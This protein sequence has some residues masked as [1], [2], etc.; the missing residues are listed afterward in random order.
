MSG[1][2]SNNTP[3]E[4]SNAP[5][6]VNGSSNGNDNDDRAQ[7]RKLYGSNDDDD[8]GPSVS[9]AKEAENAEDFHKSSFNLKRTRSMGLLDEYIDPMKKLL[10]Q[11]RKENSTTTTPAPNTNPSHQ[12][13]TRY[14]DSDG[15]SYSSDSES[16]SSYSTSSDSDS[17][18]DSDSDSYSDSTSA[19]SSTSNS[20]YSDNRMANEDDVNMTSTSVSPPSV[21]NDDILI[22][23]DDNDVVVEPERH[24]DYLSHNW[25]EDEISN[26]WKYI[27][28]KKKKRDI[29][30]VNAA[31]LENASW[32]TWAKTRNHLKTVSPE[33][34]NWSKDSD[35]TWLYGPIV[36][37]DEVGPEN[38]EENQN[39][40]DA[41]GYGSDDET[42]K[43]LPVINK[44][45]TLPKPDES[46]QLKP[47][48]KKRTVPEIIEENSQ[49][50]LNEAKKHYYEMR[51]A[52]ASLDPNAHIHDDYDL[53]AAKVN[54]Q[55]FQG[56]GKTESQ[57]NSSGTPSASNEND[58]NAAHVPDAT[59]DQ[60]SKQ[61]S[62]G[63]G[64]TN[65]TTAPESAMQKSSLYKEGSDPTT[66]SI[67]TNKTKQHQHN[68]TRPKRHIH[69]NDRVEQCM[70]VKIES[71]SES[72]SESEAEGEGNPL[73]QSS[74]KR[75]NSSRSMFSLHGSDDS[76][77][78]SDDSSDSESDDNGDGLFINARF[79]RR[80]NSVVHSPVSTAPPSPTS[81][82]K[83]RKR[84]VKPA[85][86]LLPATTLNYGSD[87]ESDNSDYNSY[88]NAVSH[89]VN[90]QR[91]YD[92]IYDYNSVYTGDTSNFLPIDN[93]DIVDVPDGINLQTS[94]ADSNKSN[95]N[96]EQSTDNLGNTSSGPKEPTVT[97]A[98]S[99]KP[100]TANI[101]DE[102]LYSSDDQYS[103]SSNTD[104]DEFIE[105]SY[106]RSSGDEGE[107]SNNESDGS[108][109][110]PVQ[111]DPQSSL[112]RTVSLG[113]STDSLRNL[114]QM[115][116]N[117]STR[118]ASHSFI[119]GNKLNDDNDRPTGLATTAGSARPPIAKR[120]ST[121]SFIF[122]S[123]SDDDD[124]D[125]SDDSSF[126]KP[127]VSSPLVSVNPKS[128]SDNAKG[129]R[130]TPPKRTPSSSYLSNTSDPNGPTSSHQH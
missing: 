25:Q 28:L 128:S 100:P 31:R 120:S 59:D 67:L 1:H 18:S 12:T 43:L 124:S 104:D 19:S 50:R 2:P 86:K 92:Y 73:G 82:S 114:S 89:N 70:V 58:I 108:D 130:L 7:L 30:L 53:L 81:L 11:S 115:S 85:I 55:Y 14:R 21:G 48:L 13:S 116:M 34:V 96:F 94:I 129:H 69:F 93:C 84:K 126:G 106:Y 4:N 112:K 40:F 20:T 51:R 45:K 35:V 61:H 33:V 56:S 66:S 24:V 117:S 49:W 78:S 83:T 102:D 44:S 118:L 5:T 87:E 68:A 60:N 16:G 46:V 77:A 38:Q 47:I 111:E 54:A 79:S 57:T 71:D 121:R 123:D 23:Q 42:S 103:L 29:D 90:T 74:L 72:S 80:S 127:L 101:S 63:S 32:R 105:D 41:R 15:E 113:K 91:G 52:A 98:K 9:M 3:T 26:S 122:N 17:Y 10:E 110:P 65:T 27:I 22:P 62:A 37:D 95:Y 6:L 88:G 107:E 125:D 109:T 8:M 75:N 97:Y 36:R 64:S 76:D 39:P 99:N 119:T